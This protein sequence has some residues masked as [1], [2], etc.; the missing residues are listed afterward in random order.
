V[1][2]ITD[3]FAFEF[4]EAAEVR[5]SYMICSLP[6]TGSSLLCELLAGTLLAGLP[7]E[8]FRPDRIAMLRRRWRVESFDDY[9]GA[10]LGRKTSPNG[11]FGIKVHWGQYTTAVGDRDPIGLFPNMHF[12]EVRRTDLAATPEQTVRELLEFLGV[13]LPAGFRLEPA[14]MER[15]S[16]ELSEEWAARYLAETP[17]T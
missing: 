12:V 15:Q 17:G 6:R 8:Y 14:V 16:D 4:E 10:L 2:Q 3:R 5:V 11:V 1:T 9:L 13:D 7:A